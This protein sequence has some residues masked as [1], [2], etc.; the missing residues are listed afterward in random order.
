[1]KKIILTLLIAVTIIVT[2]AFIAVT[3]KEKKTSLV[4]Y[5]IDKTHSFINFK[6]NRFSMVDVVGR[7]NEFK[8]SVSFDAN[9]FSKTSAE[10]VIQTNSV[11]SGFKLRENATKSKAF[12]DVAS[13]PEIKFKSKRA[14]E[15]GGKKYVVGDFTLHGVTK[16]ITLPIEIKGP[17][18]DPTRLS[19][20]AIT[21]KITVNRQDYGIKF[22]RKLKNGKP[23][24]GNAVDIELNILAVTK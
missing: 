1:M 6:V 21:S 9:D 18:T 17:F 20:V 14:F 8:G 22:N 7:F 16:E 5:Q 4:A 12:L 2:S 10:V 23:F 15:K 13:Y 24:I 11:Y 3:T 19:T